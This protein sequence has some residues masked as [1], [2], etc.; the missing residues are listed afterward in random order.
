MGKNNI[1]VH[2]PKTFKGFQ[3]LNRELEGRK[4]VA[5]DF[6]RPGTVKTLPLGDKDPS[7]TDAKNMAASMGSGFW[8]N[9]PISKVAWVFDVN[10]ENAVESVKGKDGKPLGLGFVKWGPGNCTPSV[11]PPLAMALPYTAAPLRY[12]AD[13]TTG[14]GPRLM[15]RFGKDDLCEFK[16]AGERLLRIIDELEKQDSDSVDDAMEGLRVMGI[17]GKTGGERKESKELQRAREAYEDWRKTWFGYEVGD[18]NERRDRNG[19]IVRKETFTHVPGA[20]EFLEEN[21]I[22]LHMMQC[23][24]DDVMLDIYFPMVGLQKGRAGRWGDPKIVRIGFLPASIVRLEVRDEWNYTNHCY[25]SDKWRKT[26]AGGKST[27]PA[28][29]DIV[30]YPSAMPQNTL[31]KIREIV[32]NNQR[33]RPGDRPTWIICPTFYPSGNKAYYPQPAWWSVFTSLAFDFSSTILY[34]KAKARENSTSWGKIF[35]VSLDYINQVF[36]DE[37]IAGDEKKKEEY[38]DALEAEIEDFLQHRENHGKMMRQW[39]WEGRDGKQNHNIEIVDVTDVSSSSV[40]AGKDEMELSTSPIFLALQVDPRLV[41]VPMVAASNGGTALREMHLLKQ[42]QLNPKQ[43]L[44]L[45]FIN[46]VARYNQWSEHAEFHIIQQTLTTLDN[47]KTGTVET[48]A[49]EKA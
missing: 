34:D 46:S 6:I 31:G 43:R 24:Q 5:L 40:K 21:N 1:S 23:M 16:D 49:G 4:Y 27:I 28:D 44:Y 19:N 42:Q 41:G 10:K 36:E 9:G 47:S 39:M 35:Y 17:G 38:L 37:G 25:V 26:V 45:H 3:K 8:S 20:R 15:Y 33:V 48:V 12:I 32:Q 18:G 11:V 22:D 14:L 2:K 7:E 13:L 30:M 29:E